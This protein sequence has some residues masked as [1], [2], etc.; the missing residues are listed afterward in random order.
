L[1]IAG[2]VRQNQL[3]TTFGIGAIVDFV[4]HAVMI[5]GLDDWFESKED[6]KHLRIYNEN[7]QNITGAKY[8]V[9]PKTDKGEHFWE[10]TPDIPSYS[11]PEKMYCPNCSRIFDIKDLPANRNHNC[12][13][14]NK[15]LVASRFVLVCENGHI[16]DFPYSWWVHKGK[17]CEKDLNYPGIKM[18][19]VDGRSDIDSVV[20]ECMECNAKRS[21]S[22]AFL[23]NIFNGPEGYKCRGNH[24]HLKN[25]HFDGK[26][27]CA[28]PLKTRLRSSSSIYFPV[29]QSALSIPPWSQRAIQIMQKYY[30]ETVQFITDPAQLYAFLDKLLN[31]GSIPKQI[32][33]DDL[34]KAYGEIK[35]NKDIGKVKTKADVSFAEYTVLCKGKMEGD[36]EYSALEADTPDNFKKYFDKIVIVDKLTVVQ[37][38]AGFT[39]LKPWNGSEDD[40]RIV[41]LFSEPKEEFWLPAVKNYGEGIFFLFNP[42]A[43][44]TWRHS[45]KDRYSLLKTNFAKSYLENEYLSDEYILLHTFSHLLIRQLADECGYNAASLREKIYCTYNNSENIMNGVL[46]YLASSD[47]D[48]SLGG[49]ISI[50]QNKNLLETIMRKMI[51][52]ALWC[53]ADPFCL[54]S[55]GQ[56]FES[57]NYA[58]CHDCTLLPETSCE[59]RNVFLDRVSIVGTPEERSLGFM[60]REI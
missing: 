3:I 17:K 16:E 13:V 45:V 53:S 29:I 27:S 42:N 22:S 52:K 11:F 36:D 25:S 15:P 56:G 43:I 57:L 2:S 50:A 40:D 32:S 12:P 44:N 37:A 1:V 14:C 10:K 21:M 38:L 18:Y 28:A 19:N 30:D 26:T 5:A 35:K 51:Q 31:D 54:N 49:L 24:P 60:Y 46:V 9:L 58:A 4:D 33:K 20:I 47:S 23:E 59:F 48:G 8:F 39:R 55:K 7:L 34:L 6:N 41:P